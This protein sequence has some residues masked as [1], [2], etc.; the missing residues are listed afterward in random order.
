MTQV[1][2]P[3]IRNKIE[4]RL[5]TDLTCIEQLTGGTWGRTYLVGDANH[6]WVLRVEIPPRPRMRKIP[7]VQQKAYSVGMAV[8]RIIDYNLELLADEK[9]IWILEEYI[10]GAEFS[11]QHFDRRILQPLSADLGRQ[12]SLLHT[13]EIDG[14]G[15]LSDDLTKAKYATWDEW[16]DAQE[17]NIEHTRLIAG[18]DAT[19]ISRIYQVYQQLRHSY[20]GSARLCHGDFA[21]DNLIIENDHLAA[22]IDWENAMACDPAYDVAYWYFWRSNLEWLDFLI[23]GYQPVDA[24]IF[25]ER[26]I[27]H[28]VLLS[29]DFIVYYSEE[30]YSNEG[31]ASALQTLRMNLNYLN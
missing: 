12:L 30:Q 23:P 19:D 21:G 24:A 31:V 26:I 2:P 13:I 7:F 14:F 5:K 29:L 8:P 22:A 9:F 3:P 20:K 28:S 10:E 18:I 16:L 1:V 27:C 25:R 6:K 15:S 4:Q 17:K 11:T